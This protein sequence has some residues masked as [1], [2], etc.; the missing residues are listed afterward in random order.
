MDDAEAHRRGR[1]HVFQ[2]VVDEQTLLGAKAEL[3][4][5]QVEDLALRLH[6]SDFARDD[7]VVE[8]VE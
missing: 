7:D 8:E 6:C 3:S 5:R 4:Q 2:R 1:L